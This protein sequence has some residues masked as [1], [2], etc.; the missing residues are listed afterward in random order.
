M[1]MDFIQVDQDKCTPQ[2]TYQRLV[3]RNP[4]Q[5]TWQ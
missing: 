1:N 5:V 2:Y 4:L 3:D